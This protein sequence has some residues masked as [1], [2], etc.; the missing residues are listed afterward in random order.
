MEE[1][2]RLYSM[3]LQR[4]GQDWETSQYVTMNFMESYLKMLM[5]ER[6]FL[7]FNGIFKGLYD[8]QKGLKDNE[9][10]DLPKA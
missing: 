3:G 1:P 4:V 2:D 6:A 7:S 9:L 8:S 5:V 10:N